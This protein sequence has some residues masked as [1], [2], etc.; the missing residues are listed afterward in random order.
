MTSTTAM[1]LASGDEMSFIQIIIYGLILG[2]VITTFRWLRRRRNAPRF[3]ALAE[4]YGGTYA[5]K[6]QA[7]AERFAGVEWATEPRSPDVHDYLCGNYQGHPFYCFGWEYSTRGAMGDG[8][9][10]GVRVVRSVYTVQLPCYVGYFSVR[11]HSS[12]RRMFGQNDVQVGHPEFDEQFTVNGHEPVAA[13]QV[14][15]G[16]LLEFLLNDSRSKD[17]P[18]WFLG[19]RLLCSF[20]DRLS[21]PDVEPALEF[22]AQVVGALD[23]TETPAEG[24]SVLEEDV[25]P[26]SG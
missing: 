26:L 22:M 21:P 18:L 9:S 1:L 23:R 10:G 5:P 25:V 7:R 24:R 12:A 8:E 2:L 20:T 19:D 13:Q 4:R 14:L 3:Q 6:A 16:S 11:K 17:Y 15:R